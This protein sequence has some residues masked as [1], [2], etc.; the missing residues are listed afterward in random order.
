M[1][2]EPNLKSVRKHKVPDWFHDA[3]LGIFVHWG[4]YSVP[5]FAPTEQGSINETM[6]DQA[7]HFKN[8]PY[9]EW[10]LNTMKIKDSP[11]QKHHNK[12]YGKDFTYFSFIPEFNQAIKRW[13][14]NKMADLFKKVGARYVVLVT[15]HHDGFLL[16]P[17]K[18]PNPK[19]KD[20]FAK[21][22]IVGELTKAV[23]ERGMRMGFYYS[24]GLDWTFNEDPIQDFLSF[25]T[26]GPLEPNYHEYIKKH[27]IELID[28]YEPSIIWNDI[29]YPPD[30][31]PY[32]IIAYFYNK[33]PD[34]LINDRWFQITKKMRDLIRD[35]LDRFTQAAKEISGEGAGADVLKPPHYDYRTPEY[36]TYHKIKKDKFESCRGIGYSFGFNREEG[37][38]E[39][40]TINELVRMFIDI[41]SKNGNLLLNVGPMAD[42]TIPEMQV[43]RLLGLG[44]WLETNGEAIFETRP[45]IRAEGGTDDGIDI[46]FTQK[47]DTLYVILL[48]TPKSEKITIK[49][50]LI[51]KN[52]IINVLGYTTELSWKQIGENLTITISEKL[53]EAPA[54]TIK[55]VPKPSK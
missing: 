49:T 8:N 40:I 27:F 20:H 25:V 16:W 7:Y 52:A 18:Y 26:N 4:I 51:D 43:E 55:I 30:V 11:T 50:L 41:V 47:E 14:P 22:N 46:R 9:A 21:R 23:K 33:I 12:V 2:Y 28:L 45:W 1:K 54:Y 17:S 38:K 37:E 29:G 36:A 5:A 19:K 39:H 34:G 13:E 6:K 3:K 15:K 32:E 44:R 24:G 53:E 42:G 48:D 31:N 10:Y 35:N